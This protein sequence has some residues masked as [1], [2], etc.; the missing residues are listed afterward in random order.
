MIAAHAIFA[1]GISHASDSDPCRGRAGRG[2]RWADPISYTDLPLDTLIFD[3]INSDNYYD[4]TY[5]GEVDYWKLDVRQG[6]SY[7]AT[8]R[9]L[10]ETADLLMYV[11]S[12][13]WSRTGEFNY[14]FLEGVP[15]HLWVAT[16]DDEIRE[17]DGYGYWGDPR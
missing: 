13:T 11:F 1:G 9:R 17:P 2:R 12:T 16:G 3:D 6:W 15:A 5:P 7:T 8:A 14:S 4:S 10:E